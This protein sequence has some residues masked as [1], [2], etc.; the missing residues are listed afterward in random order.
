MRGSA[1]QAVRS[2]RETLVRLFAVLT[3]AAGLTLALGAIFPVQFALDT[4]GLRYTGAKT[5][6]PVDATADDAAELREALGGAGVVLLEEGVTEVSHGHRTYAPVNL[7]LLVGGPIDQSLTLMPA[8]QRVGGP[9]VIPDGGQKWIDLNVDV[10]SSLQV[11]PGDRVEVL[12]GP[13]MKVSLTVRGLYATRDGITSGLAQ[14]PAAAFEARAD[15][16]QITSTAMLT[17]ADPRTVERVLNSPPWRDRMIAAGYSVP[18]AVE[19]VQALLGDAE[20]AAVVSFSVVL[21]MSVLAAAALLA[22]VLGEA[23][24][25]LRMLRNRAALLVE[26]GARPRVVY[27]GLNIAV[28]STIFVSISLGSAL[29]AL[30]HVYGFA[31]PAL[32]PSIVPAWWLI[33]VTAASTGIVATLVSSRVQQRRT[34]A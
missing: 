11:G 14:A 15:G 5:W 22:I 33:A 9:A 34:S 20:D 8:S 30:A 12:A 32:P 31:G 2:A 1:L 13:G 19:P 28:C 26:L 16:S 29:G 3:A 10:A 18:I 17:A 4:A 24:S 21:V 23:V 7:S 27:G 6:A 25:T